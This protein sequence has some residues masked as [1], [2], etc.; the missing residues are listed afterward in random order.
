[1]NS[2]EYMNK[3]RRDLNISSNFILKTLSIYFGRDI[4]DIKINSFDISEKDLINLNKIFLEDYPIEYIKN[5]ALFLD[6]EYYV[7]KNVLI[8]RV[9]TE[10]LV[11]L[12]EKIIN[13]NNFNTILDLA[14]GSG[15]IAI[16][17]KMRN[18]DLIVYASDISEKALDV[19]KKNALKHNVEIDFLRSD[20]FEE[21]Q[22]KIKNFDFIVSNPP[23]VEELNTY[24]NSSIKHEPRE[25][26]FS[27]KDGQDFF[28]K[29]IK[30][31]DIIKNKTLLF[32]TTE[33]NYI[34][35]KNILYSLGK[36][37][38]FKDSFGKY[39]FILVNT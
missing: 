29:L 13:E 2:I 21:M 32:E 37:E 7:D 10:D 25:A 4:I 33:F 6:K 14:T 28:R 27:G 5:T 22:G 35:T 38:V 30:Y 9:E 17:L 26:L 3:I 18:P 15:V 36:T 19:A 20:I 16:S 34:K 12:A 8:P 24:I 1:M 11:I 31:K 39:R 23:Y